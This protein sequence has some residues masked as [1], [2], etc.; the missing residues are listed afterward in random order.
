MSYHKWHFYVFDPKKCSCDPP[1]KKFPIF[2]LDSIRPYYRMSP[3]R[4]FDLLTHLLPFQIWLDLTL[5]LHGV[6]ACFIHHP[7]NV[8]NYLIGHKSETGQPKKRCVK[9]KYLY[10]FLQILGSKFKIPITT[11]ISELFRHLGNWHL[12]AQQMAQR[13]HTQNSKIG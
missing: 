1:I 10:I 5:T 7:S 11:E 6:I 12:T 13:W 4:I 3:E 8:K 9:F 2:A